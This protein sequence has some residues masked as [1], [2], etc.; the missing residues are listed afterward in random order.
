MNLELKYIIF[1]YIFILILLYIWKPHIFN[2]NDENSRKK[3]ILYL[4]SLIII[5]AIIS[6][7]VKVLVD[8][9]I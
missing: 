3:K 7:Y 8:W 2:L 9:F 5:I 1:M 6:F 4:F